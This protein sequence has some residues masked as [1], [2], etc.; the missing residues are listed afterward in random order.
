MN[1]LI[2]AASAFALMTGAALAS[3][4]DG[5]V[6]KIN[7]DARVITLESGQSYTVPRDVALPAIQAGEK[8]SI[9]LN[10]EGDRVQSVLR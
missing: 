3:S 6:A 9:Q 4:S 1:K 2:L 5:V 10:D 7:A 8:I